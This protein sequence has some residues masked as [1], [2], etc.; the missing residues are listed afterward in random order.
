M[1]KKTSSLLKDI[2]ALK[3]CYVKVKMT[4]KK[5]GS[6]VHNK[7][8]E[9]FLGTVDKILKE[10]DSIEFTVVPKEAALAITETTEDSDAEETVLD[11]SGTSG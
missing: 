3:D 1:R 6:V 4:N 11:D 7:S 9:S 5:T 8:L 10:W 2:A